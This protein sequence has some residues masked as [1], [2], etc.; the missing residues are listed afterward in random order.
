MRALTKI[1]LNKTTIKQIGADMSVDQQ[2]I[3]KIAIS[4]LVLWSENPRDPIPETTPTGVSNVTIIKHA[5]ADKKQ[6]WELQK[7][8]KQMGARYDYSELP[9]VVFHNN[10]P[11]VYDGNRR[12]ILAKLRRCY[13][14]TIPVKFA[15]PEVESRMYCCVCPQNIALDSVWRKHASNGSWDQLERD[16][17]EHKFMGK[18]KSFFM[19]INEAFGG[20]IE[21]VPTLNKLHIRDEVFTEQNL[22]AIGLRIQN[23]KLLSKHTPE[24]TGKI[25]DAI[26]AVVGIEQ[27]T[28]IGRGELREPLES[29]VGDIIAK[30]Q[31][32]DYEHVSF[33]SSTDVSS[34]TNTRPMRTRRTRDP[35]SYS[36]FGRNLYLKAGLV[37]NMYRDICDLDEYYNRHKN[38]LSKNFPAL[39]R[40]SLRLLCEAMSHTLNTKGMSAFL[41]EHFASA[42]NQLDKDA[43]TFL[44]N[45]SVTPANI[46]GMFESAGH[47]YS[48]MSNYQQTIAM[49]LI[50]APL[51]TQFFGKTKESNAP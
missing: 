7:L 37:S 27:T 11:V 49:S 47:N 9:I 17:F 10:R 14:S 26:I 30:N 36:L 4:R 46:V 42:K 25:I 40:M 18:K 41:T 39:I 22:D 34:S 23:G 8:A 1:T 45:Q 13:A 21:K 32:N 19:Q 50:L 44:H 16:M 29:R 2:I 31:N 48:G 33:P 35:H 43:R 12:V 6:K 51:I 15:L 20:L 3:K 38:S 28:R 5:L 24:E